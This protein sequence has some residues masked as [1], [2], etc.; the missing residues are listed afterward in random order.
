MTRTGQFRFW[1]IGLVV[2]GLL[3]WLFFRVRYKL[4]LMR[5]KRK[6]AAL[7]Q[8]DRERVL[9]RGERLDENVPGSGLGLSIVREISKLYRGGVELGAGALGG[10]CVRLRLPSIG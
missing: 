6:M 2:V 4:K 5:F 7:S 3:V 9:E 1:L 10:L 8:A